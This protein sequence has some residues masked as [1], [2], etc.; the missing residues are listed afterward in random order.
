M[1]NEQNPLETEGD[2]AADYLEAFLDIIDV[3]GDL[4]MD[5]ENDR[6]M[7]AI[8]GEN[9]DE[10]VGDEGEVLD[11]LQD[12]ARLAVMRETGH[13]SRMMLDVGNYRAGLRKQLTAQGDA[14]VEEVRRTGESFSLPR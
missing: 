14:A 5:V 1:T 9:L 13:R 7:V 8:V 10:L 3:D 2:I 6:A 12:L 11:A 4:E